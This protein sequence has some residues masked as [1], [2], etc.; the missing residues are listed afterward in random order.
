MKGKNYDKFVRIN[1]KEHRQFC[2]AGFFCA[3]FFFFLRSF[4]IICLFY[5]CHN[6]VHFL[7]QNLNLFHNIS[8][9]LFSCSVSL[10]GR[11]LDFPASSGSNN[12]SLIALQNA[13][14]HSKNLC[15]LETFLKRSKN[16]YSGKGFI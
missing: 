7:S 13:N 15:V 1:L 4:F 8:A 6:T 16:T 11:E 12:V 10:Y 14:I 2:S 3:V 9:S 5:T